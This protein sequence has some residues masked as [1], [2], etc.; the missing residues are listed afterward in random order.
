MQDPRV[1]KLAK[2]ITEYSVGIKKG[3]RV[4]I[5]ASAAAQPLTLAVIEQVIKMGGFPH[6]TAGGNYHHLDVVPGAYESLLK[7][8]SDEQIQ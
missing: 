4:Y 8:G 3:D 7:Y 2:V 1:E 6:I 5:M